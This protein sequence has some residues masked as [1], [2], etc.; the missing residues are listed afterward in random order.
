MHQHCN[1]AV[2]A[3]DIFVNAV[4]VIAPALAV[5]VGIR[6]DIERHTVQIEQL[7]VQSERNEK[8]IDM[9]S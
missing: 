6:V 4:T 8:R 1:D 5:Y 9:I 3:I 7:K 2:T